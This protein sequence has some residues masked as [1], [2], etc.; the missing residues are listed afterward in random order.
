MRFQTVLIITDTQK[1]CP[2][3]FINYEHFAC[4][5]MQFT[6]GKFRR[7]YH[8][9]THLKIMHLHLHT[10]QTQHQNPSLAHH[11]KEENPKYLHQDCHS[12]GLSSALIPPVP[13][14]ASVQNSDSP[15]GIC[16]FARKHIP[17]ERCFV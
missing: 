14:P 8:F 12:P 11:D 7:N 15:F 9:I 5:D 1:L 10:V 6:P 16:K 3:L 2:Y 4:F 13:H 17:A